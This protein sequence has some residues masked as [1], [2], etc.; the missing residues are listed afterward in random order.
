VKLEPGTYDVG[1][2]LAM[3]SHID[4]QG[5]GPH[6]T[7]ISASGVNPSA[8]YGPNVTGVWI[9]DLTLK[10][11][12][13]DSNGSSDGADLDR[14]WS[15]DNVVID[16]S[17]AG[18][19]TGI[20]TNGFIETNTLTNVRISATATAGGTA[21]GLYHQC[22]AP[23]SI[24]DSSIIASSATGQA[25]GYE[26]DS[27]NMTN[28]ITD[29]VIKAT[30]GAAWGAV[31]SF[32]DSLITIQNSSITASATPPTNAKAVQDT[33]SSP[34]S[35]IRVAA[36]AVTGGGAQQAPGVVSCIASYKGDFTTAASNTCN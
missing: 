33:S 31:V 25:K 16:A 6:G 18:D 34:G 22:C 27:Q 19:A 3:T 12:G 32:G 13:T 23:I 1:D 36:S 8:V 2:G 4:L 15:L 17:G 26:D 35:A 28:T 20:Y 5:S 30:G 7:I 29:T 9:S 14:D 10:S 11:A 24:R 21:T